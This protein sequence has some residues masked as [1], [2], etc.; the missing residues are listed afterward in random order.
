MRA[1]HDR[2]FESDAGQLHSRKLPKCLTATGIIYTG[3]NIYHMSLA[4]E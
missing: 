2:L 3:R 4:G 1:P